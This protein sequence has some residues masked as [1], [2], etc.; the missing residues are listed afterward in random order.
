MLQVI[1]NHRYSGIRTDG[2]L[3]IT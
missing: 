2:L 3:L 1:S